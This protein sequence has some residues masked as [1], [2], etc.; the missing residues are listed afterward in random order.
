MERSCEV[1]EEAVHKNCSFCWAT[2]GQIRAIL[3]ISYVQL[4]KML[5]EKRYADMPL[6]TQENNGAISR[7]IRV[8]FD[9]NQ[10]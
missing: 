6:T 7:F 8:T 9:Q 4:R 2:T 5:K 1:K 3:R 10:F